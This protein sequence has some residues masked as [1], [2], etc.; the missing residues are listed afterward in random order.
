VLDA[1]ATSPLAPL[2]TSD[3]F[4]SLSGCRDLVFHVHE[5][6]YDPSGLA[7]LLAG[8]GLTLVG[9]DAPEEATVRFR[10][11]HGPSANPLDLTLWDTVEADHPGLFA[12]MYHLWARKPD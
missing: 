2:R 4:Y 6:A 12:G 7:Y 10:E 1:P 5:Q 11:R 3:D 8:A 9:F